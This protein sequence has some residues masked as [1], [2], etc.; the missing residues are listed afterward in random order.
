MSLFRHTAKKANFIRGS[1][2]VEFDLIGEHYDK[3]VISNHKTVIVGVAIKKINA[4]QG[5]L[6]RNRRRLL[7]PP[8]NVMVKHVDGAFT[9]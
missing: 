1:V 5:T 6:C 3:E 8:Q 2:L 7:A 9:L 4:E